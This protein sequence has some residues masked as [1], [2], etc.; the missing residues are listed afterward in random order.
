MISSGSQAT[1]KARLLTLGEKSIEDALSVFEALSLREEKPEGPIIL[2]HKNRGKCVSL[3]CFQ[4]A[5]EDFAIDYLRRRELKY[6][7]RLHG[8]DVMLHD[9]NQIGIG[10]IVPNDREYRNTYSSLMNFL[11]KRNSIKNFQVTDDY[12]ICFNKILGETTYLERENKLCWFT[13]IYLKRNYEEIAG[14]KSL[15]E[16][17]IKERVNKLKENCTG[18]EQLLRKK[19]SAEQVFETIKQVLSDEL[20]FELKSLRLG[21]GEKKLLWKSREMLRKSPVHE[22]VQLKYMQFKQSSTPKETLFSKRLMNGLLRVWVKAKDNSLEKVSISGSF[23][24]EPSEKLEEFEKMLEGNLLEEPLL[25]EKVTEFFINEKIKA[26][27]T[28]FDVVELLCKASG[29]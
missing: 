20:N 24:F 27:F 25:T 10:I 5:D 14:L 6:F 9:E 21:L 4:I 8:G 12:I 17:L 22:R 16:Q 11:M 7:Y 13:V 28:P 29:G 3:G 2:L 18:L 1:V 15:R 26:S 19:I 23:M